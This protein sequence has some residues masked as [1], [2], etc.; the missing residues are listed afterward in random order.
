VSVV[1]A[2]T[3]SSYS[4]FLPSFSAAVNVTEDVVLRFA[5][6]KTITRANPR[7]MLP[8]ATFSD[9]SAQAVTLG[10]PSLEPFLSTNIDLGG[11]WYT[12]DEGYV[13]L[14]LFQKQIT[15]FTIG[16]V[17]VVPFSSLAPLGITFDTLSPTQ[18]TA[19]NSRGGA[20]AA[21][22]NATQQINASGQLRIRGYEAV[23]VQPLSVIT[24][25]LGFQLNYTDVSQR[26]Q[27]GTGQPAVAVGISPTTY[28]G[29][30]YYDNGPA[31]IR[32]SYVYNDRQIASGTNQEGLTGNRFWTDEYDQLDLSASWKFENV[33]SQPQI[34]LNVIN[35]TGSTQRQTWGND[36]FQYSNA[37]RTFYDPGF[38]V[39][40]GVRGTF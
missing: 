24:E 14:T 22:V 25:G 5:G 38:A 40:L 1:Q 16:N 6:S 10:N 12:G 21:T 2:S 13:G 33:A 27:G 11:E 26:P 4:E 18:Q 9:P 37:A 8:N 23:W 39:L 34:T 17:T 32:L 20:G 15:G 30:I 7:D 29:T 3:D 35:I 19:I 36:N 28:N 31:S